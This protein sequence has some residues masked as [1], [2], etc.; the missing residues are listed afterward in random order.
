MTSTIDK[1]HLNLEPASESDYP[2]IYDI[3]KTWLENTDQS[4]TLLKMPDFDEYFKVESQRYIMKT[5]GIKI[6]FVQILTNNEMGLVLIPEY[7]NKGFGTKALI[8]LIKKH[9]RN[10]Y[11]ATINNQ[12]HASIKIFNKLG[13]KPKGTIFELNNFSDKKN[14]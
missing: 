2:F 4:V 14:E 12:N 1:N 5:N 7:H 9:P 3:V 11:F 8:E 13:F 6:G 10:K